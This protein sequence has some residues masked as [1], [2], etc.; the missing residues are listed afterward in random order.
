MNHIKCTTILLLLFITTIANADEVENQKKP[1]I[2]AMVALVEG[3]IIVNGL[4]ASEA[5]KDYGWAMTAISPFAMAN[6]GSEYTKWAGLISLAAIGQYNVKMGQ[7][8]E[9]S[10][11]EIF[12]RNVIGLHIFAG[13]VAITEK[14]TG[15]K[16]ETKHVFL[17][18]NINGT[19]LV[20][21]YPF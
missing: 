1:S 8:E 19:S 20:F 4:I 11:G 12:K 21:N 13:L 5:P 6:E 18:P 3:I 7:D 15:Q 17:S 14:L 16:I 10:K 9:Y 2:L